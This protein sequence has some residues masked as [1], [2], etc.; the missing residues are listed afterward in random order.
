VLKAAGCENVV[1]V[2]RRGGDSRFA[3]GIGNRLI[4][5][6][7]ADRIFN[8]DNPESSYRHSVNAADAVLC[9]LGC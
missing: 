8:I 6:E 7:A 3:T 9:D 5:E 1:Y 4:G 2:S